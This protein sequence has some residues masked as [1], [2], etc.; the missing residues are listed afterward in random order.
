MKKSIL[1]KTLP[2][3]FRTKRIAYLIIAFFGFICISSFAQELE[4]TGK[5]T[6]KTDGNPL[7]RINVSVKGTNVNTTTDAGGNYTIRANPR[8]SLIFSG[9]AMK[10]MEEPVK[11]REL[12][13]VAMEPVTIK[14]QIDQVVV[15]IPGNTDWKSTGLILQPNDKIEFKATGNVCFSGNDPDA[16]VGPE[17]YPREYYWQNFPG[18][19]A[20]CLDPI[21]EEFKGPEGHAGLIAKVGSGNI[22]FVG[23]GKTISGKNGTLS[24]GINDCTFAGT[25]S[26]YGQFS[27]VIKVTRGA[28]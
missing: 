15:V 19:H 17:G 10:T 20:T 4:I 25:Y 26:N 16:C 9:S 8:G 3:A 14:Q 24:I 13:I 2:P 27:V 1:I 12:I 23:K 28:P 22:F 11:N 5:V 7:P 18:D 6:S 21:G